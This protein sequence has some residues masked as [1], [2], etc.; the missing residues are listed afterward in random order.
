MDN[1]QAIINLLE[2]ARQVIEQP[3]HAYQVAPSPDARAHAL[4]DY[5]AE[6]EAY[7]ILLADLLLPRLP[8]RGLDADYLAEAIED[9]RVLQQAARK[10]ELRLGA[11]ERAAAIEALHDAVRTQVREM[12][13]ML[14]PA[15][16]GIEID[17]QQ[18]ARDWAEHRVRLREQRV[19]G[20]HPGAS[21]D[22]QA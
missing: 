7:E 2:E 18:L 22:Q 1:A 15:L 20:L 13:P 12:T 14:P 11:P 9:S 21:G 8:G 16:Q 17:F 10:V 6:V 5:L 3:Y 4:A 19:A